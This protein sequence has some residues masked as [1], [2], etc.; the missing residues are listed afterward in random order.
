MPVID[1][2]GNI[3][4]YEWESRVDYEWLGIPRDPLPEL[5]PEATRIRGDAGFCMGKE[6]KDPTG[7]ILFLCRHKPEWS[8]EEWGRHCAV[9]YNVG[10]KE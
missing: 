1:K 8:D 9:L 4:Y 2:D 3:G 10:A 7:T 6:K 5:P